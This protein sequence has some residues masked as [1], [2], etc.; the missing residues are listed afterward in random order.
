MSMHF[1]CILCNKPNELENE[2]RNNE[3]RKLF[4][5]LHRNVNVLLHGFLAAHK[6]P[7]ADEEGCV[8]GVKS[9][10]T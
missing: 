3:R 9:D 5:Y 10:E 7:E 1:I 2:R 8:Y 4:N 6:Q